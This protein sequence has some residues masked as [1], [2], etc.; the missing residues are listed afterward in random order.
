MSMSQVGGSWCPTPLSLTPILL[1]WGR[2]GLHLLPWGPS[3]PQSTCF[4]HLAEVF[5][6]LSDPY[7]AP[8]LADCPEHRE[9][10]SRGPSTTP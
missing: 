10:L 7:P 3:P 2:A 1:S 4:S 9:G 5:G 8:E 6:K